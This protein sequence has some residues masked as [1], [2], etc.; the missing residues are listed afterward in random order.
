MR[1]SPSLGTLEL[2]ICDGLATLSETIAMTAFV[3]TLGHAISDKI[4]HAG[5]VSPPPRWMVRDNKWRVMRHGLDA[6]IIVD[7]K[8]QTRPIREELFE[9]FKTLA[10]IAAKLDYA[11]H[12]ALLARIVADGNSSMRQRAVFDTRQSMEDVVR[13]NVAEFCA[14]QPNWPTATDAHERRVA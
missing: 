3:H 10:P 11:D 13:F 6:D 4:R 12:F 2:R 14:G 7:A 1:P 9:L 8:G 5:V